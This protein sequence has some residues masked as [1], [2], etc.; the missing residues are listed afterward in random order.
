MKCPQAKE[1]HI[2]DDAP[3]RGFLSLITREYPSQQVLITK[4]AAGF[5][6]RQTVSKE[7]LFANWAPPCRAVVEAISEWFLGSFGRWGK[8]QQDP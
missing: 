2:Y 6:S 7:I 8:F 5:G 4:A 3:L 1:R